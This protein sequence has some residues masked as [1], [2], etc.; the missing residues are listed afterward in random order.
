MI[1]AGQADTIKESLTLVIEKA[2]RKEFKKQCEIIQKETVIIN[3]RTR[4]RMVFMPS[5]YIV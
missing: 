1:R 5:K 3:Q 4:V 2:N